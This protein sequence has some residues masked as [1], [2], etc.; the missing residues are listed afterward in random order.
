MLIQIPTFIKDY[1]DEGTK[2]FAAFL[3]RVAREETQF[4]A[5]RFFIQGADA[6]YFLRRFVVRPHT[7]FQHFDK[8]IRIGSIARDVWAI[9]WIK[10][11]DVIEYDLTD[12]ELCAVW[13][14]V[15]GRES[16]VYLTE[17]CRKHPK[18]EESL[19]NQ[20]DRRFLKYTAQETRE[21]DL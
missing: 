10:K 19:L 14:Y 13:G 21:K 9:D 15:L 6:R 7:I 12:P 8:W 17:P 20:E 5:T 18:Q 4:T 1:E 2:L 16:A 3:Y 11:P